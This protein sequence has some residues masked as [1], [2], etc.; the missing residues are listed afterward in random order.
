V[1][2]I[3]FTL[4]NPTDDAHPVY[5]YE[6][7]LGGPVRGTF[8]VD[9]QLKELGCA[10]LPQPYWITTYQLPAHST[11]ATTTV[12]M[13]DGGSF[14][15]VEFGVTETQPLPYTPPMGSPDGCSPNATRSAQ[16]SRSRQ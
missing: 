6:K 16:P 14:Y 12:T 13:T 11:G 9:G 4:I 5:L 7:P 8:L 1:H 2:R 10:R 3:T 15:P